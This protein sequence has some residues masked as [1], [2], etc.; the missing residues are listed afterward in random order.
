MVKSKKDCERK[1]MSEPTIKRFGDLVPGDV[2]SGADGQ[3]VRVVEA[4]DPHTP[5]SMY[6]LEMD[7]GTTI[8]ASGNHLWYIETGLDYSLHR[9]R[10]KDGRRFLKNLSDEALELLIESASYDTPTET[11]LIDMVALV[12]AIDNHA[13]TQAIVRIAESIG[14]IAE[15]NTAL[16]DMDTGNI[17]E[18]ATVRTYDA[19]LFSQQILSL[20]GARDDRKRWP[21][22][23]G[24]VVTTED[25]VNFYSNAEIP[26]MKKHD[27]AF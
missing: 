15:N 22:L 13:A 27:S 12:D 9:K 5:D 16:E 18:N 20:R 11:A 1:I 14:H 6:E 4:Y 2:I 23:V 24:R 8:K 3:E 17:I 26:V 7:D 10:R 19:K 25:I 21:L